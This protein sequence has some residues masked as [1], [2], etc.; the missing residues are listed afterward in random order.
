MKYIYGTIAIAYLVLVVVKIIH[1][2][3][4]LPE[5]AIALIF[6]HFAGFE[7]LHKG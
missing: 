3:P 4:F 5:F 1:G 2:Q 7:N 6:G